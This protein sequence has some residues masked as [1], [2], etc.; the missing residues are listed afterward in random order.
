MFWVEVFS[1]G[2]GGMMMS[3]TVQ[4]TAWVQECQMQ[5]EV[6]VKMLLTGFTCCICCLYLYQSCHS[7]YRPLVATGETVNFRVRGGFGLS[8]VKGSDDVRTAAVG[9]C[10]GG[11]G[12]G[13]LGGFGSRFGSDPFRFQGPGSQHQHHCLT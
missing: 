2:C 13:Q 12:C 5:H 4:A 8:V 10:L 3:H 9:C 11:F 7:S 1:T 6:R